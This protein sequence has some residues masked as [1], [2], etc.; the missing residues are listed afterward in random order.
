[1]SKISEEMA[2]V[3]L[4]LPGEKKSR[5]V[6]VPYFLSEETGEL[7]KCNPRFSKRTF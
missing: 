1:M 5:R 3:V 7:S 2:A 4:L 6:S